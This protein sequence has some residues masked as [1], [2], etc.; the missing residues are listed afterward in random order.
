MISVIA[1]EVVIYFLV[2]A[3]LLLSFFILSHLRKRGAKL[4]SQLEM[5]KI[6]IFYNSGALHIVG[7][8][9][10]ISDKGDRFLDG[11]YHKCNKSKNVQHHE[12]VTNICLMRS[13]FA[14]FTSAGNATLFTLQ[15]S[16]WCY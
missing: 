11:T 9:W 5:L 16:L 14:F 12:H 10:N 1:L 7:I 2:F 4:V 8:V 13:Q 3:L 15:K 6:Q